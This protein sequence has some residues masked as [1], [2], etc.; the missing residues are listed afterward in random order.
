MDTA[1]MRGAQQSTTQDGISFFMEMNDA[2]SKTR[3]KTFD[4]YRFHVVWRRRNNQACSC[5]RVKRRSASKRLRQPQ[6][7]C[8]AKFLKSRWAMTKT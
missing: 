2:V 4:A 8:G 3:R 5:W 1:D 6:Q 7:G